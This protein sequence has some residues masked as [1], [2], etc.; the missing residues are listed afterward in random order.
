MKNVVNVR[1]Y[2]A[3]G[4]G[5]TLDTVAIQEA[6][7]SMKAGDVLLFDHGVFVTGTLSLKSDITILID[8]TAELCASRNIDHYRDCGFYHNEM[9]ETVS[10]L[11]ALNAQNITICGK[12]KIQLSGDAFADFRSVRLPEEIDPATMTKEYMEQTVVGMK[13]RPTQP[14]FF[15]SCENIQIREIQVMNAP[16]WGMVFSNCK[17]ILL[18][19]LY[20]DNH[21]RIPNN[22]GV[23]FS[24]SKNIVVRDCTFLCGDD[25]IAA[26]CIT[27][28]NGV[29][30]NNYRIQ[31]FT[32]RETES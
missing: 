12:G 8:E 11:Y 29:C 16:C 1:N 14:I 2:G 19:K 26:T 25:C 32:S 27:N 30:E 13:K 23:H 3:K 22:D 28:W 20:V 17:E 7:D 15:D 10:L 31:E 24:A 5:V 4:D 9:I 18:E 21:K 6:I